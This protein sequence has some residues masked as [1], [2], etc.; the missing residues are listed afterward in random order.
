MGEL[1][2]RAYLRYNL[3]MT[4][5]YRLRLILVLAVVVVAA[6]A[7]LW[8]RGVPGNTT[9]SSPLPPHAVSQGSPLPTTVPLERVPIPL[10]RAGATLLW[11][12]L[13]GALA[14]GIALVILRFQRGQHRRDV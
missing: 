6:A 11:V 4:Q 9:A 13:G 2:R 8:L 7:M 5:S 14:L 1:A 10:V 12:V 3:S